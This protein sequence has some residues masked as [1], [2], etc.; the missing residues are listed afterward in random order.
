MWSPHFLKLNSY[1]FL[2]LLVL[3]ETTE[4][5]GSG[6]PGSDL[7]PRYF[8]T[9]WPQASCLISLDRPLFQLCIGV[10]KHLSLVLG[11]GYNEIAIVRHHAGSTRTDK[12]HTCWTSWHPISLCGGVLIILLR[13]NHMWLHLNE[14]S[15]CKIGAV[16]TLSFLNQMTCSQLHVQAKF[17]KWR[18]KNEMSWE[19]SLPLDIEYPYLGES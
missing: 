6:R 1:I 8:P 7:W 10:I 11:G 5:L 13:P 17:T 18:T 15:F 4:A 14:S 2:E 19:E 16:R 12:K 9:M 3:A